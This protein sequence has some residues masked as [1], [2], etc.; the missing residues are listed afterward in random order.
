REVKGATLAGGGIAILAIEFGGIPSTILLGWLSDKIGGRRGMVAVLCMV[1]ILLA[2]TAILMTPAGYLW[3]DMLMLALIGCFI[4]PVINFIVIIALDLS[5]K[6]AIGVA[7]GFIGLFGYIGRTVQA[8]GFGAML[9]HYQEVYG[10]D[11]AWKI[12][13]CTILVCT[14]AAMILLAFTW[15]MKPRA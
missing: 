14:F 7:A 4:Y 1:P 2:F 11:T 9:T 8:K 3:L 15:K 10:I 13:L 12:V 5:S 6:K